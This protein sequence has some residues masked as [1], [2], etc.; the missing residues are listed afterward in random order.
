MHLFSPANCNHPSLSANLKEVEIRVVSN[1]M[2]QHHI[3]HYSDVMWPHTSE[4]SSFQF[5]ICH[6]RPSLPHAFP[7][8]KGSLR[9]HIL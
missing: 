5:F 8:S 6:L 7:P 4:P 3:A 2:E 1:M 9:A